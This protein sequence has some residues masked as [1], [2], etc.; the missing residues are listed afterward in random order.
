MALAV[1]APRHRARA[2]PIEQREAGIV[3]GQEKRLPAA[4]GEFVGS[5]AVMDDAAAHP[6]SPRRRPS[7]P[8]GPST[9][10]RMATDMAKAPQGW[11]SA[12]ASSQPMEPCEA[13][14]RGGFFGDGGHGPPLGRAGDRAAWEQRRHQRAEAGASTRHRSHGGDNPATRPDWLDHEAVGHG[15][16]ARLGDAAGVVAQRGNDH[17]VFGPV[18]G[19]TASRRAAQASCSASPMR[20]RCPSIGRVSRCPAP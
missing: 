12:G 16:A 19:V 4:L 15:H 9:S 2:K 17:R 3:R 6:Q 8:C 10:V 5:H 7:S 20:A 18:L 14:R 11:P 13:A 1:P